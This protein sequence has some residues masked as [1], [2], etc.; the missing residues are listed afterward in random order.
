MRKV[1]KPKASRLQV[2]GEVGAAAQVMVLVVAAVVRAVVVVVV[3]VVS[4]CLIT[5]VAGMAVLTVDVVRRRYAEQKALAPAAC[6]GFRGARR[7]LSAWQS[8]Q[9]NKS[10]NVSNHACYYA[11]SP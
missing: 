7:T 1:E 8:R 2:G 3:V 9:S 5:L 4:V 6:V 11:S 10:V